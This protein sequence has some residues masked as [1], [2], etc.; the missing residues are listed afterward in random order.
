MKK[1][2][3]R[4]CQRRF[5]KTGDCRPH[6]LHKSKLWKPHH[7]VYTNKWL[8]YGNN[9]GL[10]LSRLKEKLLETFQDLPSKL[11][12]ATVQRRVKK[13][14]F[15]RKKITKLKQQTNSLRVKQL[16][17]EFARSYLGFI[18]ALK[19]KVFILWIDECGVKEEMSLDFGYSM[20]G[21]RA[22]R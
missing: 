9:V 19:S 15:T 21:E 20:K 11:H 4:N 17:K 18:R 2:F 8:K 6:N 22:V 10:P 13:L 7:D 5:L 16:R 3:I 14:G 1:H 12:L